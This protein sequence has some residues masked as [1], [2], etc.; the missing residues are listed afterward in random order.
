MCLPI[1]QASIFLSSLVKS[2]ESERINSLNSLKAK[3]Y[4]V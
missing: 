2:N 4:I 3:M 1:F